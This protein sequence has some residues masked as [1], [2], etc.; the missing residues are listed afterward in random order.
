MSVS[1][2]RVPRRSRTILPGGSCAAETASLPNLLPPFR[3]VCHVYDKKH[4]HKGGGTTR[5]LDPPRLQRDAVARQLCNAV[6]SVQS[7][8][9]FGLRATP[10]VPA[11][12]AR[13]CGD[14]TGLRRQLTFLGVMA[15]LFTWDLM[16]VGWMSTRQ[17][18]QHKIRHCIAIVVA[19]IVPGRYRTHLFDARRPISFP[20]SHVPTEAKMP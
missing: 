16:L 6:S 7:S 2:L 15:V 3:R 8:S 13:T 5:K 18:S 11:R 9:G 10:Q 12:F 1:E 20:H 17:C 14:K 4:E 19:P